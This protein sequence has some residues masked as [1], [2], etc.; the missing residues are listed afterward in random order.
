MNRVIA[1]DYK[2]KII[3]APIGHPILIYLGYGKSVAID[4]STVSRHELA[5]QQSKTGFSAGKAVLGVA[6]FGDV[7]ALAGVNGKQKNTYQ[8]AIYFRDGKKSLLEVDEKCYKALTAELFGS[9]DYQVKEIPQRPQKSK[10]R[11]LLS[12]AIFFVSLYICLV[13]ASAIFPTID[14]EIQLNAAGALL[15][16]GIPILTAAF[17]PKVIFNHKQ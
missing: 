8:V 14:G 11:I 1:G 12:I 10:M 15:V 3:Q 6:A 7:G 2:D 5:G 13:V 9:E 16:L 4:K 17:L